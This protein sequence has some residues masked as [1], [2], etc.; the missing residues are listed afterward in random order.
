MI[1][2]TAAL[3]AALVAF[4]A[5]AAPAAADWP[6]YGKD[7]A[8]TRDGRSE[9]P[10]RAQLPALAETW[11]FDSPTGDFTGTPVVAAGVLVAGDYSGTV[12]ALDAVTGKVRWSKNVGGQVNGSAAIDT[13]A[14]GGATV[15]VP[16]APG[17]GGPRLAALSLADGRVRWSTVL[18]SQPQTSV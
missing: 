14:P 15:F 18:T 13:A 8:N 6:V 4:A 10:T 5:S 3:A 11:R 7:L 2:R 1:R 17:S 16:V 12:Y 9:G